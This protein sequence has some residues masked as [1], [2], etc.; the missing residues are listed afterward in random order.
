MGFPGESS[1]A[2]LAITNCIDGHSCDSKHWTFAFEAAETVGLVCNSGS[3]CLERRCLEGTCS[4]QHSSW[5]PS[6]TMHVL[7]RENKSEL[8]CR[9][10]KVPCA[11]IVVK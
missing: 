5:Y 8:P 9:V 6:G 4:T 7:D 11:N 10:V 2:I 1:W 3:P